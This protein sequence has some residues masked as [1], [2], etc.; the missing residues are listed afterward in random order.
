MGIKRFISRTYQRFS[1]WK[2]EP[3]PLP[4]KGVIIG[5]YHTSNWDGVLMM[6]AMWDLGVPFKFLVKDSLGSGPLGPLIRA[7]G[8]ISVD[9]SARH[10]MV[11]Q[12]A[13]SLKTY[14]RVQLILAPEG[15]RKRQEYWKSGFYHI[16]MEAG[17][18][19]TL[20][21]IDSKRMAYG[22][23]KTFTP[24]GNIKADMDMIRAY[25]A[26]ASGINPESNTPP[27]LR[28]EE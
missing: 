16:A 3:G 21:Y 19:I 4:D 17:L 2:F 22:W 20:A 18:P 26:E 23:T 12:V 5:A 7:V 13:Q 28:N 15:T 10:G 14:D 8:G 9:R 27:R 24:T 25:Y 1:K 6:V 11:H